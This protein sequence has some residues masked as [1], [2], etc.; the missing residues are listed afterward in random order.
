MKQQKNLL[1]TPL[2]FRVNRKIGEEIK[3][4]SKTENKKP[5]KVIRELIERSLQFKNETQST[6]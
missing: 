1:D 5:G 2:T 6:N 4:I 3:K